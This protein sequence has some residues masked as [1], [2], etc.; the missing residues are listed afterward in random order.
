MSS[1]GDDNANENL[2]L[3][4][5]PAKRVKTEG[6]LKQTMSEEEEKKLQAIRRLQEIAECYAGTLGIILAGQTKI[7]ASSRNKF[8]YSLPVVNFHNTFACHDLQVK[9][10]FEPRKDGKWYI[11]E[12][13]I[14]HS[15]YHRHVLNSI[16]MQVLI[17]RDGKW[18]PCS[19]HWLH[20][21]ENRDSTTY[22]ILDY[23]NKIDVRFIDAR[24]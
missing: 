21:T 19:V 15:Y 12:V 24:Q 18:A 13:K 11:D 14:P 10:W 8:C 3:A 20:N 2:S 1:A 16:R 4:A 17:C 5:A 6:A 7:A 9:I 22:T 23:D